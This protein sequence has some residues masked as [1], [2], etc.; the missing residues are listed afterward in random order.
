M[1]LSLEIYAKTGGVVKKKKSVAVVRP[2]AGKFIASRLSELS[3]RYIQ[4]HTI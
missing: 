4:S 1:R 2:D 3:D